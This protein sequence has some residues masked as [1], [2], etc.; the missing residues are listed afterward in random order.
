M[1]RPRAWLVVL[2]QRYQRAGGGRRFFSVDCNF[3]PT[4]SEYTRQA[5]VDQGIMRGLALGWQRIRRC[6]QPHVAK[7]IADPYSGDNRHGT[8]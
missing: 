3:T 8:G 5:V 7:K 6:N 2:I 1:N 4:C